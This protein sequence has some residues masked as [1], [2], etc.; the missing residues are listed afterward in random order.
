MLLLNDNSIWGIIGYYRYAN[1]KAVKIRKASADESYPQWGILYELPDRRSF[2]F[3]RGGP[4]T[5]NYMPYVIMEYKVINN[6]IKLMHT[7]SLLEYT[8]SDKEECFFDGKR[9][10]AEVFEEMLKSAKQIKYLPNTKANL[11]KYE[12]NSPTKRL[13]VID[14]DKTMVRYY[15]SNLSETKGSKKNHCAGIR[16]VIFKRDKITFYSSFIMSHKPM[17]SR[18]EGMWCK[19]KKRTFRLAK[20][21][22][23]YGV[24]GEGPKKV[25]SADEFQDICLAYNCLDLEIKLKNNKVVSM[26]VKS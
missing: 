14:E 24:G 9:C 7:V 19:Y 26:T 23:Y 13:G 15:T 5:E 4:A 20:K 25:Y 22:R 16:K 11:S 2:A 18:I 1:G 8:N 10:K 12:V 17:F 21:V 3:Y 6:Q